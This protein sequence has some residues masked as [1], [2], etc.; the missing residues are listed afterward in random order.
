MFSADVLMVAGFLFSFISANFPES[1]H[2]EQVWLE[3]YTIIVALLKIRHQKSSYSTPIEMVKTIKQIAFEFRLKLGYSSAFVLLLISYILT[4]YG[5]KQLIRQSGWV[6]NTNSTINSLEMLMSG[7]KDAETGVRGFI[8]TGDTSFLL[9][10]LNSLAV[11]RSTLT[12][13]KTESENN[14]N[15]KEHLPTLSV[16]IR[17]RYDKLQSDINNYSK[18]D[19]IGTDT[20]LTSVYLGKAKMDRIRTTVSAM[21]QYEKNLLGARNTELDTKYKTL[22]VII[23]VSFI[24]ALVFAIFG[25]ITYRRE[26]AARLESEKRVSNY[27]LEL[28]QR[29]A[30]LDKAN[31]ELI[32]MRRSEKFA[33]TGRIARTIAHEV[34]NPLTNIDL[35]VAQLKSDLQVQDPN[36]ITLFDMVDRNSKRINQLISE[37]LTA[38]RFAEL[39]FSKVSV[40]NLLDESLDLAK[41]RLELNHITIIKKYD[42]GI[43]S[44][45]VDAEKIKIAFLNIIVNAIEAMQPGKGILQIQT[46]EDENKCVVEITDNGY[47][48]TEEQL[49]NLFE[50]YFTTKPDGNGLG[51]TN[52]Q[53]IIL[54]H[55]ATINVS[56]KP[57]IGTSFIIKFKFP[58]VNE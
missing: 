7:L 36:A 52:T 43:C 12:V 25:F 21:Q 24:M 18:I 8:N 54:N 58:E 23:V 40:N 4:L 47:G 32:L 57:G 26:Y 28:Q 17:E 48:M 20:L 50:P 45:L 38:T 30:E 11:V 3:I 27:Q 39:T 37:L 13:L 41:D 6:N 53:N 34:R 29:I 14:S 46:F 9:P 15:L 55:G 56:S 51:L 19:Y 31:K 10:Y 42:A 1:F 49:N 5:N 16:L 2:P 44:I 22:N 35:A 33:A